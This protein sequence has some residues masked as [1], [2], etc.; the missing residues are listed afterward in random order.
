MEDE[1]IAD[2]LTRAREMHRIVRGAHREMAENERHLYHAQEYML[3]ALELLVRR[4]DP[5][6]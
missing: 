2:L 5:A 4:I 6:T 3:E 1:R